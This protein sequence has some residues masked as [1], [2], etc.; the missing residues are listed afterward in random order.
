M[1]L[2]S[3]WHVPSH[4]TGLQLRIGW[5]TAFRCIFQCCSVQISR[6]VHIGRDR[7]GFPCS[8]ATDNTRTH[9]ETCV[10]QGSLHVTSKKNTSCDGTRSGEGSGVRS[11]TRRRW[12]SSSRWSVVWRRRGRLGGE[13]R[14]FTRHH[15][16]KPGPPDDQKWTPKIQDPLGG[17][18]PD[19]QIDG[20]GR[21]RLLRHEYV[22]HAPPEIAIWRSCKRSQLIFVRRCRRGPV[23][24]LFSISTS[25]SL[26]DRQLPTQSATSSCK[27]GALIDLDE[28][29][30]GFEWLDRFQGGELLVA[31][32]AQNRVS[33]R[34]M[35]AAEHGS[36]GAKISIRT[37]S[38][39]SVEESSVMLIRNTCLF[40]SACPIWC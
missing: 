32:T 27:A 15:W 39:K 21:G 3:S 33:S 2:W 29:L 5:Q 17:R 28:R 1:R 6:I 13:G 38:N 35:F 8:S 24:H 37:V 36:G 26:S 20:R 31:R 9:L 22:N 34:V 18:S 14:R 30:F 4:V 10:F 16:F 23:S 25:F 11:R 19:T 40:N 12:T 7:P